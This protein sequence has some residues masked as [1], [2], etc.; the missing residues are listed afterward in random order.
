MAKLCLLFCFVVG[1]GYFLNRKKHFLRILF[2]MGSCP[3]PVL[4]FV[5]S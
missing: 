3:N 5:F 4:V 2:F 1:G